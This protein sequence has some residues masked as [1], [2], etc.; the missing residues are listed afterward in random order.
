M[1]GHPVKCPGAKKCVVTSRL[2]IQQRHMPVIFVLMVYL[3]YL[4]IDLYT[5]KMLIILGW[6][7]ADYSSFHVCQPGWSWHARDY[8]GC[9]AGY[10]LGEDFCWRRK[11]DPLHRI[12]SYNSTGSCPPS[13]LFYTESC[14]RNIKHIFALHVYTIFNTSDSKKAPFLWKAELAQNPSFCLILEDTPL[15][16]V[17]WWVYF[18][19]DWF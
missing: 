2:N 16:Q 9:F 1:N 11:E 12:P 3:I 19:P 18:P 15:L 10:H 13:N 14:F 17:E 4:V 6:F 8:T 7:L 5:I